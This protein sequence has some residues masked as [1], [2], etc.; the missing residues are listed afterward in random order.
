VRGGRPGPTALAALRRGVELDDGV[1]APAR[2]RLR[3]DDRVEI[4]LREGRKRQVRRMCAA[5]GHPVVALERVRLGP[6][7]LGTLAPGAHRRL[8]DAEVA[9]LRAAARR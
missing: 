5:V 8:T 9:R 3:A 1:T 6:L 7:A 2:A 4:E